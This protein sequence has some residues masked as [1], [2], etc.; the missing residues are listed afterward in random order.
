V[1]DARPHAKFFEKALADASEWTRFAD[2]KLLGV[3][4]L[5]GLGVSNI[6][7]RADKLWNA[8]ESEAFWGWIATT[9]LIVSTVLAALIVLFVSLGLFPRTRRQD[10]ARPSLLFFSGIASFETPDAYES[11]VRSKTHE[12]LESEL[13][14]QAWE[15]SNVATKKHFWAGLAYRTVVA[16]LA[17]WVIG[18]IAL[19]L[20]R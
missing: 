18:W 6:V 2:P 4:I 19:L 1:A 14:H 16:F 5:L 15:V 12:Q 10:D 17:V 13:A 9:S 7:S 3:L 8:H 20:E 11:A